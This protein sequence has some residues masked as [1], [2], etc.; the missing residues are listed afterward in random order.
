[1]KTNRVHKLARG[2]HYERCSTPHQSHGRVGR[3]SGLAP[4][5]LTYSPQEQLPRSPNEKGPE[6][7]MDS[8]PLTRP[9]RAYALVTAEIDLCGDADITIGFARDDVAE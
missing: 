8:S 6:P 1:M 2:L 3:L 4:P 7:V 5:V 9:F